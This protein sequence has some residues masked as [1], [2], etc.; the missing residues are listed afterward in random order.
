VSQESKGRVCAFAVTFNR[1]DLLRNCLHSLQNGTKAPDE[2]FIINNASS[3][4][5]REMLESE[6][7]HLP[8]LHLPQNEGASRGYFE[9]F[10]Y[11]FENGFDFVWVVDDE[12]WAEPDCLQKLLEQARPDTVVMPLKK[13]SNGHSYGFHAWRRRQVDV[14]QEV[15]ARSASEGG[16]PVTGADFLFDFTSTLVPRE[17]IA[18]AGLPNKGFFIWF[19]DFEYSFRIKARGG[20][21]VNVPGTVFYHDFGQNRRQVRFLGRTS[22]RS[23]QPAWKTYYGARNPLYT[24]M[25]RRRRADEIALFLAVQLRL[26]LMDIAYESDRWTRVALRFKGFGDALNGRLGK[27]I[28]PPGAIS[29][30]KPQETA[31]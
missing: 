24:L 21:I 19:D 26:M 15:I 27:R 12:G 3:D 2:I 8:A 28:V 14:V 30:S 18:K 25:R 17:L 9:G 4:G 11:G 16:G 20:R 29:S 6:F 31:P 5:T 10:K 1:R 22:F 13:D 7:P 23:D